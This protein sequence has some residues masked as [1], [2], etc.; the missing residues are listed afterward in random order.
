MWKRTKNWIIRKLG[1]LVVS[2]IPP[3]I[4]QQYYNRL[5]NQ[6]LDKSLHDLLNNG[7]KVK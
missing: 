1:G 3:D 5:Y 6:A 7:F 4:L 2:D